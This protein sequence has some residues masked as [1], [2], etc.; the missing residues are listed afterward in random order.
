MRIVDTD[1]AV[2]GGRRKDEER[3]NWR[4][5]VRALQPKC[6]ISVAQVQSV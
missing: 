1:V 6:S 2:A 5:S 4:R 3:Q